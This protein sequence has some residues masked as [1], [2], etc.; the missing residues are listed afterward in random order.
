LRHSNFTHARA[1]TVQARRLIAA[2]AVGMLLMAPAMAQLGAVKPL[3]EPTPEAVA[4]AYDLKALLAKMPPSALLAV[5]QNRASIIDTIVNHWTTELSA[6]SDAK[7]ALAHVVELRES[8][9][10]LRADH[11]MASSHARTLAGLR[12]IFATADAAQAT[13]K[14]TQ[15]EKK[16]S[17]GQKT[18][19]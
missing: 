12:H 13:E 18:L 17:D 7:A 6:G 1:A 14:A 4:T 15:S 11:L 8:L 2:L 19:G 16:Q 5:D 10:A 3:A 9:A